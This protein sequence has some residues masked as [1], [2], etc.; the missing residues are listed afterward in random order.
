MP[1]ATP[2][3]TPYSYDLPHDRVVDEA[4]YLTLLIYSI[5]MPGTFRNDSAVGKACDLATSERGANSLARS[6]SSAFQNS[7]SISV[8]PKS[9]RNLRAR[10][11]C[12]FFVFLI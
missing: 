12:R 11:H 7:L 6:T 5:G 3:P 2:A 10:P 8:G 1:A 4:C 9:G